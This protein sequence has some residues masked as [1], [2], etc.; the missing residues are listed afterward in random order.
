M[1]FSSLIF[2][3]R[4]LPATLAVY[5]L[6]PACKKNLVLF[7][8]SLIF[9]SW[10]EVRF[11]PVMAVL[12]L[13]N[14]TTGRL[15]KTWDSYPVLRWLC[16]LASIA[17]SLSFL[18]Y[19]KYADFVIDT[20]NGWLGL[21][22]V[23]AKR[24]LILPLGI[25]FY[26]FQTMSYSVDVYRREVAP[27]KNLIRFGAYVAMFPQLIAGPIVKY[28]DIADT[29][30]DDRKRVSLTGIEAGVYIFLAGL[31]QKVLIADRV[32]RLWTDITGEY[33]NGT[34]ITVGVGL[35]NA[36]TALIWLGLT[37]Y[38][39]QLFFDF[40][41]YSL[42]AIGLGKML[43]F[44]F[45]QN[46]NHPYLACSITEFWRRWHM[47][48]SGWFREYIYIP[49][50]GSY[51]GKGRQICN[52][53]IVWC[54]TGLWHGADWNFL[55]WGFY[56]FL[57]LTVEK[58]FFL[59]LLKRGKIWPRIYTLFCVIVGWGLF[60]G[61]EPGVG[62]K[63]LFRGL[64]VWQNGTG[65]WFFLKNYAVVLF[66][67]VI[68]CTSFPEHVWKKTSVGLRTLTAGILLILCVCYITGSSNSPFLY[69]NF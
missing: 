42:M 34:L 40:S 31:A 54:L 19:F 41:G 23:S 68:C 45:P 51:K 5:Y 60:V 18:F 21:G 15:L 64:F 32:G 7:A 62:I 65:C 8:A 33:A 22:L 10:G 27:E 44:D 28:R 12:I 52:L 35:D 38:S 69:F 9:Y 59:P 37:A 1:V 24:T 66:L 47:T 17:G 13:L 50:G 56:Y 43:G 67:A 53:L 55:L 30:R 11:F 2:L 58:L 3:F 49:L 26:T 25:S 4:F 63:A 16:L 61:N 14:Y 46:F 48:L 29:L 57:L 6:A 20:L 39:L 36:S